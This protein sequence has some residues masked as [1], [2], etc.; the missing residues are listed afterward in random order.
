[1]ED[2]GT[3]PAITSYDTVLEIQKSVKPIE[4]YVQTM[5]SLFY[6]MIV[7]AAID[8]RSS[9]ADKSASVSGFTLDLRLPLAG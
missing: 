8:F 5:R 7:L 1:M 6:V 9:F 4:Q 3:S 2:G